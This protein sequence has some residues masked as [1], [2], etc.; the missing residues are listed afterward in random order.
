[1]QNIIYKTLLVLVSILFLNACTEEWGIDSQPL[2]V[3][4]TC[5]NRSDDAVQA[6]ALTIAS[7]TVISEINGDAQLRIWHFQNSSKAVCTLSG[8]AIIERSKY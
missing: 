1:M 3:V 6:G 5:E 8:E 4:P 7:G 2:T